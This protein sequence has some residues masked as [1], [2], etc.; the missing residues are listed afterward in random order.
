MT[1]KDVSVLIVVLAVMAFAARYT[2]QIWKQDVSPTFSTW[3]ILFIGISLS[4]AT[5]VIA[6]KHDFYAG[7]LNAVDVIFVM[8]VLFAIIIWG[9]R[10]VRFKPFEKW[11][12]IGI[13]VIIIYGLASGDA[14]GSNIFTQ[15]LIS[16]GYI[17]TIQRLLTE[18]RNV[19]SF[20]G[21]ICSLIASLAALYPASGDWLATVYVFRAIVSVAIIITIMTYY[22]FCSKK[23][24]GGYW[25]EKY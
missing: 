24:K 18:K 3:I 23:L 20:S 6:E 4:F 8:I 1:M 15:I 25:H 13:L 12:L 17:P 22:E 9:N 19:E 5:Y 16:I 11:Y 7:V 14:W 2:Y 21:W 10:D